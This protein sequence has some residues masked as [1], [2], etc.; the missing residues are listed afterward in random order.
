LNVDYAKE[1]GFW[2]TRLDHSHPG[3]TRIPSGVPG[4]TDTTGGSDMQFLRNVVSQY[5]TG[6]TF[7]GKTAPSFNL[8]IPVGR[9]KKDAS[10]YVPYNINSIATNF[11]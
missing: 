5:G 8:Y 6:S 11:K 3:G 2:A 7:D 9:R 10:K 4:L 1:K